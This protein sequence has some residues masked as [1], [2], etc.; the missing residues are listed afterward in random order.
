MK[1]YL[2]LLGSFPRLSH[3]QPDLD[4][5]LS[6]NCLRESSKEPLPMV[7]DWPYSPTRPHRVQVR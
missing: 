6:L 7:L 2:P 5:N 4:L 1:A 3:D